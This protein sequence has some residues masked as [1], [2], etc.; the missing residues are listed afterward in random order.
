MIIWITEFENEPFIYPLTEVKTEDTLVLKE[1]NLEKRNNQK[2]SRNTKSK[3][4]LI[5]QMQLT[6][7]HT[8]NHFALKK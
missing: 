8:I 2:M 6:L 7:S 5:K 4:Y 3:T 1:N